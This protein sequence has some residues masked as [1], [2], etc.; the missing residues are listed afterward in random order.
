METEMRTPSGQSVVA[1]FRVMRG[2]TRYVLEGMTAEI[3]YVVYSLDPDFADYGVNRIVFDDGEPV[4]PLL[5]P[6]LRKLFRQALLEQPE[7]DQA[8]QRHCFHLHFDTEI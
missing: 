1:V 7:A 6:Q 8:I 5:E 2:V 3:E 4:D